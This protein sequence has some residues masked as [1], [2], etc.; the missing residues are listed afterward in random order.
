MKTEL[1]LSLAEIQKSAVEEIE[2]LET[3]SSR[4]PKWDWPIRLLPYAKEFQ[5]LVTADT[6]DLYSAHD[7]TVRLKD[8][9]KKDRLKGYEPFIWT[10]EAF[11]TFVNEK[12]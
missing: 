7:F 8:H 9:I 3:T 2:F 12:T 1:R 10:A 4:H 6:F 5:K 11:E